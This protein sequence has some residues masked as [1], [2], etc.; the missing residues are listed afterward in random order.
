MSTYLTGGQRSILQALQ[1]QGGRCDYNAIAHAGDY[2]E[3]KLTDYAKLEVMDLIRYRLDV[4][5]Y[6]LTDEGA[7]EA[8]K[9]AQ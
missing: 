5:K 2:P 4:K 6:E 8:R 3:I 7:A 9:R 1:A